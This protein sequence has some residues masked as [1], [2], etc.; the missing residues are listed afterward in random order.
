MPLHPKDE[1]AGW[2][3]SGIRQLKTACTQAAGTKAA[4]LI[5]TLIRSAE[6]VVDR[7]RR[8]PTATTPTV[9][10]PS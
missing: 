9:K 2:L 10:E 1:I 4:H 5:E 3:D 6:I 8:D 7:I